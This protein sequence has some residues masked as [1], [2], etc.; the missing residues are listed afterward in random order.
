MLGLSH[1][2]AVA[3]LIR[4]SRIDSRVEQ[5]RNIEHGGLLGAETNE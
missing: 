1:Q 2:E 5:V 4:A 3:A